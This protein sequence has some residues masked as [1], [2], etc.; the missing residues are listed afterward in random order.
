MTT[1]PTSCSSWLRL[2]WVL[3]AEGVIR[4]CPAWHRG[5]AAYSRLSTPM[6]RLI[7][8]TDRNAKRQPSIPRGCESPASQHHPCSR[9]AAAV[10]DCLQLLLSTMPPYIS[11]V[12]GSAH[13]HI[14]AP[15]LKDSF[16]I[17]C[18][19]CAEAMLHPL[20]TCYTLD[21]AGCFEGKPDAF[22]PPALQYVATSAAS[23]WDI[24]AVVVHCVCK[25][26]PA[27]PC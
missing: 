16:C 11:Q 22:D 12:A 4:T 8:A 23:K 15:Q 1:D 21:R 17:T 20:I 13:D 18:S 24:D 19:C 26:S 5:S 25:V 9:C 6:V 3:P 27:W 10:R 2:R 14:S 7:A